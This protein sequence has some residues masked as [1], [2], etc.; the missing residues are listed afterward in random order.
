MDSLDLCN[1]AKLFTAYTELRAQ[2][3]R[4]VRISFVKGHNALNSRAS[5]SGISARVYSNGSWGFASNP[6]MTEEA[7]RLAIRTATDNALFLD[8]REHKGKGQLPMTIAS[9]VNDHS[10]RKPRLGQKELVEFTRELDDYIARQYPE[11]AS[12]T[13]TINCLDMEKILLT[14]DGS[15][16]RSMIPRS[17]IYVVLSLMKDGSPTELAEVYGGLGQFEDNFTS[18][19]QLFDEIENQYQHLVR[20]SEGVFPDAGLRP[21]ILAADLAGILAHEAI[22]HTTESDMVMSGSVAAGKIGREVASPLVTLIDFANSCGGKT[23]PVPVYVD[24]EGTKAEDAVIIENGTLKGYMHNKES[25][26]HFGV[27][28][29]GNARAYRF[30]D[31]PLVRMRNTAILPGSDNLNDMIASVDDGYYLIK[32]SN[33]QADSTSEFMFGITLGYEIKNGKIGRAI[34]DTTISGVAFDVL[35]T[36]TMLSRDMKWTSGGMCGKKQ[37]IPVGMGGPAIKCKVSIGGR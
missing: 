35:K 33:G 20:K 6:E 2:E 31:E 1:Y 36:I 32:P 30:S 15:Y 5:T 3:N 34:R 7:I 17:F 18:P 4:N 24:D 16:S 26:R 11:L 9:S 23:C 10:T 12:R 13:I 25:A 21:C 37:P 14:S 22:G 29:T 27:A 19:E 28:P 8:S